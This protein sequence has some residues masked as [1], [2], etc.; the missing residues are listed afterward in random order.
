[1][2]VL[3]EHLRAMRAEKLCSEQET[4]LE[5]A[6]Y[7]VN[8][9]VSFEYN[10]P[11][12]TASTT[13]SA[14]HSF[15]RSASLARSHLPHAP[16]TPSATT[17]PSASTA[18]RTSGAEPGVPRGWRRPPSPSGRTPTAPSS[19]NGPQPRPCGARRAAAWT[20]GT[21]IPAVH[22]INKLLQ[23]RQAAVD[24]ANAMLEI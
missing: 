3:Q 8:S 19:S 6:M 10:L 11:D 16:A 5:K 21:I 2:S 4:R 12:I 9:C 24:A 15:S 20:A 23:D 17:A 7:I 22:V 14:V 1:M 13:A 18:T